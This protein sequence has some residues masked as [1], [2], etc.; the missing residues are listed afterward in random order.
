VVGGVI[1]SITGS[2][3]DITTFALLVL[4]LGIS[5]KVATP[6]SVI[7][8]A[9]N[10]VVGFAWQGLVGGG[11]APEAWSYWWVCVPVVVI[12][13]PFGAWFIRD[14]SRHFVSA[15]LYASILVQFVGALVIVPMTAPLAVFS[16]TVLS[17]GVLFF[18][19]MA[20]Q[21]VRRMEWFAHA[22]AAGEPGSPR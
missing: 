6:T 11:M 17:A 5:E 2:G 16:V 22:D 3:L 14:R 4:R 20:N 1:S 18:R 8:M 10:A 13:A 15:I 12:G 7:L 9:C 21:G 19:W